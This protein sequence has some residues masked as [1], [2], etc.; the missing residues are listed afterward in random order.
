MGFSF[1]PIGEGDWQGL[2]IALEKLFYSKSAQA[3]ERKTV[4]VV[5]GF[6]PTDEYA[7]GY[8]ED[9]ED[10]EIPEEVAPNPTAPKT[11][12][13]LRK[14]KREQKKAERK[15]KRDARKNK[16]VYTDSSEEY[17]DGT[18]SVPSVNTV[19][20]VGS[21]GMEIYTVG[22][23]QENVTLPKNSVVYKT[24]S[25]IAVP[26]SYFLDLRGIYVSNATQK[27]TADLAVFHDISGNTITLTNIDETNNV[28][29]AGPIAG[30]RDQSGAFSAN[31]WI[32]FFFI[33]NPTT[34]DVSSL[35][36][37]S[38]TAPTL[39]TGYTF[40]V[41]TGC[42]RFTV[43]SVLQLST[44]MGDK[45]VYNT[46]YPKWDTNNSTY[47]SIDISPYVPPT[48][49]LVHGVMGLSSGSTARKMAV[50]AIPTGTIKVGA[51]CNAA[52]TGD[53]N[54]GVSGSKDFT[55]PLITAQTIWWITETTGDVYALGIEGFTDDL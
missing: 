37:A 29:T 52:G 3:S 25:K 47:T 27:Y 6:E 51:L 23:L 10:T 34:G 46:L 53:Q 14:E 48:A 33:Y 13:E 19:A 40:F 35:S 2:N 39:P 54:Y 4:P 17:P 31:S 12:K 26:S 32:H 5:Q 50:A 55:L 45:V 36:S 18:P 24:Q 30:G 21:K 1:N 11:K 41:R 9:D 22:A 16:T 38:A 44:Q 42:V 8:S 28:G 20:V 43:T 15:A 49:K 7:S